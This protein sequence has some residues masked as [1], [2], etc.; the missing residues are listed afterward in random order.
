MSGIAL[1]I[2]GIVC[3]VVDYFLRSTPDVPPIAHTVLRVV[4]WI[5]VIVGFIVI[6]LSFLGIATPIGRG[7]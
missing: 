4:G 5:C 2:V 1:L 3:L 6:L 7:W